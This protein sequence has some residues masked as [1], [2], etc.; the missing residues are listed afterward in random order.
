MDKV[1]KI[2]RRIIGL[3][4]SRALHLKFFVAEVDMFLSLMEQRIYG[5]VAGSGNRSIDL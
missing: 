2:D 5:R 3:Y 4:F 1:P